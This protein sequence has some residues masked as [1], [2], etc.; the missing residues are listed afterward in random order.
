MNL[1]A[2]TALDDPFEHGNNLIGG[3]RRQ[4]FFAR[5]R[6]IGRDLVGPDFGI[7][8]DTGSRVLTVERGAITVLNTVNENRFNL[9]AA[10]DQHRISRCQTHQCRLSSPQRHGKHTRHIRGDVEAP[11]IGGNFIHAD[12]LRHANGHQITAFFHAQPQG[13]QAI[14]PARVVFRLPQPLII[15]L[16]HHERRIQYQTG[17]RETA[18]EGGG[19]NKWFEGRPRLAIGLS[20]PVELAGAKAET[21]Y[22]GK[23]ATGM[24]VERNN[25]A[26]NLRHL[27]K[28]VQAR[29]VCRCHPHNIANRKHLVDAGNFGPDLAIAVFGIGRGARPRNSVK[30]EAADI[31][32][33]FKSACAGHARAQSN[34]RFIGICRQYNRQTPRAQI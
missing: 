4:H 27:L 6:Q 22:H 34:G 10:I 26:V 5:I 15:A 9:V 24:R 28:P 33:F 7:A 2:R 19:V 29:R 12:F 20:C 31:D 25:R 30:R 13:R 1:P 8:T 16:F 32:G 3:L 23:H 18:V 17:G 21:A 11:R 14:K